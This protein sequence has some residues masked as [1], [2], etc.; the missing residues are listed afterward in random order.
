MTNL[1][2]NTFIFYFNK[3]T[4]TTKMSKRKKFRSPSSYPSS[5]S[6]SSPS[7]SSD[8]DD[9]DFSSEDEMKSR[10]KSTKEPQSKN[11]KIMP[12][13]IWFAVTV[14]NQDKTQYKRDHRIRPQAL[15]CPDFINNPEIADIMKR[16]MPDFDLFDYSSLPEEIN[17]ESTFDEFKFILHAALLCGQVT[18]NG[19]LTNESLEL[20]MEG[21][22]KKTIQVLFPHK[23]TLL[24][25]GGEEKWNKLLQDFRSGQVK[26]SKMIIAMII[27][28]QISFIVY[29]K[30]KQGN[31]IY[32]HL[33][34]TYNYN[35]LKKLFMCT[36][37]LQQLQQS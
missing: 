22:D 33:C 29:L 5:P 23:T 15:P 8:D 10:K 19:N 28:H 30:Q 16:N 37:A 26:E 36:R 9:D 24:K 34:G 18:Y 11:Q 20:Q 35:F 12:S 31:F 2:I 27:K 25:S 1:E 21:R 14:I 4:N 7:S 32:T 6:S 13:K 17:T 3:N